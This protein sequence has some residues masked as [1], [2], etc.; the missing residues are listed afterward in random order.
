MTAVPTTFVTAAPTPIM[1]PAPTPSVWFLAFND[2][3]EPIGSLDKISITT[4]TFDVSDFRRKVAQEIS[5]FT[6]IS[7]L[8]FVVWRC[9]SDTSSLLDVNQTELAPIIEDIMTNLKA[10]FVPVHNEIASLKL[11]EK[12][13]LLVQV[14]GGFPHPTS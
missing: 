14:T 3:Y 4:I 8:A 5:S 13:V 12:E 2:E 1:S 11:G 7:P 10:S 9:Q 6:T